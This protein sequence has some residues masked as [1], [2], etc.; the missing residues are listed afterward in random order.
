MEYINWLKPSIQ[1]AI[2]KLG[3]L[4][5]MLQGDMDSDSPRWL[6]AEAENKS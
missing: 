2:Q 4:F 5:Q 6:T 1:L 3:N